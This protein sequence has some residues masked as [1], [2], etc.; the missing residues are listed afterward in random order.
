MLVYNHSI[1]QPLI[2]DFYYYKPIISIGISRNKNMYETSD[3]Y[4]FVF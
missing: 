4:L 1:N 2:S 3:N